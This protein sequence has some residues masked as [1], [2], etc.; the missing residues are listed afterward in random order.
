MDDEKAKSGLRRA[1]PELL[2]SESP[3]RRSGTHGATGQENQSQPQ[4]QNYSQ[5]TFLSILDAA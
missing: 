2:V 3:T 4:E 1:G 5:R